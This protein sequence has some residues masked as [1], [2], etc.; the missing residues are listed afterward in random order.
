M[1]TRRNPIRPKSR[2]ETAE[3]PVRERSS[4]SRTK[5]KLRFGGVSG[6]SAGRYLLEADTV[7]KLFY[8]GTV[9]NPKTMRPYF[10]AAVQESG[11]FIIF[12]PTFNLLEIEVVGRGYI[13]SGGEYAAPA[14]RLGLPRI[15]TTNAI[16]T[17][18]QAS[19]LGT[20]LYTAGALY[21]SYLAAGLQEGAEAESYPGVEDNSADDSGVSSGHGASDKA[22]KWWNKA[23]QN[24]LAFKEEGDEEDESKSGNYSYAKTVSVDVYEA[25]DGDRVVSQIERAV[26]EDVY[27]DAIDAARDD[28]DSFEDVDETY[29]RGMDYTLSDVDVQLIF[30]VGVD[31]AFDLEDG[32]QTTDTV[33]FTVEKDVTLDDIMDRDDVIA[34]LTESMFNSIE[35]GSNEWTAAL[36][37]YI[38]KT[39]DPPPVDSAP[40]MGTLVVDNL[41][42]RRSRYEIDVDVRARVSGTVKVKGDSIFGYPVKNALRAGLILD[43][44]PGLREDAL[45]GRGQGDDKEWLLGLSKN[46]AKMIALNLDLREIEDR[47]ALQFIQGI[48]EETGATWQEQSRFM[49]ETSLFHRER[50]ADLFGMPDP[51]VALQAAG[52]RVNPADDVGVSPVAE[53]IYGDLAHLDDEG[54]E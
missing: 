28:G 21:G 53:Q 9:I 13:D 30:D 17:N 14:E 24:G 39:F 36:D 35:Q 1:A 31:V 22:K 54:V 37:S 16:P 52:F 40:V 5:E 38:E 18:E 8:L 43:V 4:F 33:T 15:H 23:V 46:D 29:V 2:K 51:D 27:L 32:S 47:E 10:A 34:S 26:E 12:V 44:T 50:M 19:G 20:V 6:L 7:A 49:R 11:E 45:E 41:R 3:F 42:A 25:F 48:L